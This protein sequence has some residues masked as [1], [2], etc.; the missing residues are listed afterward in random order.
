MVSKCVGRYVSLNMYDD[1]LRHPT[2]PFS[3]IGSC[4]RRWSVLTVF[5]GGSGF[6]LFFKGQFHDEFVKIQD[7]QIHYVPSQT[8]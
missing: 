8:Y 3:V 7:S 6:K 5:F 2:G 1:M 4:S